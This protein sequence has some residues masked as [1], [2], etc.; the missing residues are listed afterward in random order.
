MD[1]MNLQ[2]NRVIL[3]EVFKRTDDR[4]KV[5]PEYGLAIEDLDIA[6]LDA[7]RERIVAVMSR[8]ERCIEMTI[9]KSEPTSM[10]A[11][12]SR[13]ADADDKL[14]L[15]GSRSVA[16][17]LAEAQRSRTIPGGILVVFNGSFGVP[18]KRIVGIIKAEV[19]TGFQRELKDGSE[20]APVGRTS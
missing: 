17:L 8:S 20:P 3:H 2:V 4:S 6:A 1:L 7:L 10:V 14:Y 5:Q 18:M 19:H 13:L 16:D 11:V 15:A 9:S 12:A